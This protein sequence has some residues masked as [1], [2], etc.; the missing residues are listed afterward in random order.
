MN[1]HDRFQRENNDVTFTARITNYD[2][3]CFVSFRHLTYVSGTFIYILKLDFYG[4]S[5]TLIRI[6]LT[7]I[8]LTTIT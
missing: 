3:I 8:S 5:N 6:S 1:I 7:W 4:N 2:A